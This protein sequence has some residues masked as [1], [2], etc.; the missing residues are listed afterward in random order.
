VPDV[1][2]QPVRLVGWEAVHVASG[3]SAAV[4]IETERRM[5]RRWNAAE[6]RW[7]PLPGGQLL[8]AR[9]LG[10][11]RASLTPDPS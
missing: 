7:D 2:D 4:T 8:L 10:D 1:A 6:E 3:E 5:W 9:G 11:V